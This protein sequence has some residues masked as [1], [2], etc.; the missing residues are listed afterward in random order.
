MHHI[1]PL[2]AQGKDI[3][4]NLVGLLYKDH[5][6][7]H[8]I[9]WIVYK[10]QKD[11]L[12][13]TLMKGDSL[14]ARRQKASMAGQ[15]GG[16]VTQALFKKLNRGWYN[17]EQQSERGKKG[18][19]VNKVQK[20]GAWD[21][22]NLETANKV[23]AESGQLHSLERKQNL[24]KGLATQKQKGINVYDRTSQRRRSLKNT[25]LTLNGKVYSLD[26][27]HRTYLSETT[28]EYYLLYAPPARAP[29]KK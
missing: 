2:H 8:L 14:E 19:A 17:S 9:R 15:V 18:A 23:L 26:H 3:K 27:E 25:T 5:I 12:A 20:T 22:T 7:A 28:F 24:Q 11:R 16:K 21:P 6:E 29:K 4:S 10:D 13:Y 1:V